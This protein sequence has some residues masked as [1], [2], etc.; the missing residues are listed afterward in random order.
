MHKF[1]KQI[2]AWIY[3]APALIL[4]TVFSM[5]PLPVLIYT[6]MQ[7]HNSIKVV[8][9]VGLENFIG[10]FHDKLFWT[11]HYNTYIMLA[12]TLLISLPLCLLMALLLDRSKGWVRSVFKF[13]A[14]LPSVLSISVI[15][16]LYK[17]FLD[18]DKGLINGI[19]RGV[20]LDNW[21]LSWLARSDT[22]IYAII[23]IG[24]IFGGGITII[25]F[26]A[27]IKAIPPQ[28]Y[29]AASIDGANFWQ[30]SWKITIPMLQDIMK[31]I[32]IT[33]VVGSLTSWELIQCLT[34][35][36]PN[37]STYTVMYYIKVT[38]FQDYN[39][40]YACAAAFVFF[41][42]CVAIAFIVNKLTDKEPLEF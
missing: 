36:G 34:G 31:Y 35:G 6:A 21:A 26:Y 37:K 15:G 42:E 23:F 1:Y 29:E 38:G 10:V 24:L 9:F 28:Y 39:F 7:E 16:Q 32:L 25:L 19:L 4:Y 22:A 11:S 27:G 14:V 13:G 33:S 5:A 41:L 20:G 2:N 18:T 17:G 40:G 12:T 30:A 8:K 3:V